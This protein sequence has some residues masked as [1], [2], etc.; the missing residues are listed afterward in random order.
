MAGL[1]DEV[2]EQLIETLSIIKQNLSQAEAGSDETT[3]TKP[4]RNAG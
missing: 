3:D 4:K 1:P 2:L